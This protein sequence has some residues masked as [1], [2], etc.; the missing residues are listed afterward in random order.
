MVNSEGHQSW[1]ASGLQ[2]LAFSTQ[3]LTTESSALLANGLADHRGNDSLPE[4]QSSLLEP[5]EDIHKPKKSFVCVS[6]NN[7][8]FADAVCLQE[9][10]Q[11]SV[12]P[13]E[14]PLD[15]SPLASAQRHEASI[16]STLPRSNDNCC[17]NISLPVP[18][19]E[20]QSN[21]VVQNHAGQTVDLNSGCVTTD[22]EGLEPISNG[23]V[24]RPP[25]D[26]CPILNLDSTPTLTVPSTVP[27][28]VPD[29]GRRVLDLPRIVKH[30]PSSITFSHYTCPSGADGHAFVNESSDD[31]A[32]SPEEE[33]E[34]DDH[35]DGDDDDD[36]DDDVFP[37]L[38]QSREL[39]V[40]HRQRSTGK[41]KQKRRGAVS[42]RAESD[43]MARNCGY[44][45][46]EETSRK[47][48]CCY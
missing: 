11:V 36:D 32:S 45:E 12:I 17:G 40:N 15:P 35:G 33:E 38:P 34:D 14:A 39:L 44:E 22:F 43:Q 19:A 18:V 48:V 4:A 13:G 29:S 27:A 5:D 26:L 21:Q 9:P 37:E 30:K 25:E 3:E 42:A 8:E 24:S 20:G 47:E 46:E 16:L 7:T 10:E 6:H 28:T 1:T 31:G 23:H 2:Q 41:D